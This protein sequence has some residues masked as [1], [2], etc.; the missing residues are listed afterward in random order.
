MKNAIKNFFNGMAFGIVE[1]VPGVSGGTIAIILGFYDKLIKSINDFKKDTKN[2]IKFLAPLAVGMIFGVLL[3]GKLIHRALKYFSLPTMLFFIGLI[4]G[5]IPLIYYKVVNAD[6]HKIKLKEALLII[7]PML[8]L[9]GISHVKGLQIG[10]PE[11]FISNINFWTMLFLV[12]AGM[13]AAAALVIPGISGSFVLLL[14]GVYP[15]AIATIDSISVYLNNMANTA[16]LLDICK[17]AGPLGL[18]IIIGGLLMV[19]LIENLLEN[20]HKTIYS[21]ILGL[22]I[23]SIY[24]LFRNDI[25]YQSGVNTML[26][27]IS[28]V[29]FAVGC[30]TSYMFGRK[31]L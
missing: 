13:V 4:V 19:R 17:V 31:K 26:I 25:V 2:S 3:F 1:T 23:G 9:I 20:H 7:I 6:H 12:L 24:A 16:L 28:V 11:E 5:I 21:I 10:A 18:G 8:F 29:T 22:L 15:V 27:C 14:I 30:I